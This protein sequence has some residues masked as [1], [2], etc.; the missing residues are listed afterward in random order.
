MHYFVD[1]FID[2]IPRIPSLEQ[3]GAVDKIAIFNA[4]IA[5]VV[6]PERLDA[7]PQVACSHMRAT[8]SRCRPRRRVRSSWTGANGTWPSGPAC[9]PRWRSMRG[10]AK[11]QYLGISLKVC[12]ERCAST[13]Y[14]KK[15]PKQEKVSNNHAF[16]FKLFRLE[17]F[18]QDWQ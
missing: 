7:L 14:S 15:N 6:R 3:R 12:G 13:K 10:G 2:V 5:S 1:H 8:R 18:A 4:F 16:Q 9:L 17:L 11:A